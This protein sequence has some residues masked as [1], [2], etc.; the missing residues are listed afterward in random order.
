MDSITSPK[1]KT[2]E[3]EGIEARSLA[4]NTSG[5][6]RRTRAVGGTRKIDRQINY[7]YEPAQTKQQVG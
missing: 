3:G 1:I 4:R 7:S 2:V 5:V 6:D